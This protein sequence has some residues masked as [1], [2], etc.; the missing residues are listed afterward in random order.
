MT[1]EEQSDREIFE[2][3]LDADPAPMSNINSLIRF[4]RIRRFEQEM[5]FKY[6]M[7]AQALAYVNTLIGDK[8][9]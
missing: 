9:L 3:E 7:H 1:K 4:G 8:R 2:I 5:E 6:G